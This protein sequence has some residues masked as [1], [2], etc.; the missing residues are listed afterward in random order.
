MFCW[1]GT[2]RAR[3]I[4]DKKIFEKD[5][6]LEMLQKHKKFAIFNAMIGFLE[7]DDYSF[8]YKL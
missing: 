4:E 2:T 8:N 6:S 3:L 1:D 7:L 5:I